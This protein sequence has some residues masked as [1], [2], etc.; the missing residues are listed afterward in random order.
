M[1]MDPKNPATIFA[2]TGEGFFNGDAIQGRGIMR[3]VDGGETFEFMANTEYM[4][5]V[6]RIAIS[7]TD[8]RV[9]LVAS[10]GGTSGGIHLSTDAGATWK[11]VSN[12]FSGKTV[13][14]HPTDG[15][16]AVASV[17]DNDHRSIYS[18]DGGVT[19]SNSNLVGEGFLGRTEL[20]YAPSNPEMVYALCG[21]DGKVYRSTDGGRTY[22][23]RTTS[24]ANPTQLWYDN[25]VWV[26][27]TN[28]ETI[29]LGGVHVRR[30]TDG[31][32]TLNQI[33]SGY[34]MTEQVH[35][36]VHLIVGDP[37]FNG[38]TN[39]KVYVCSDGG[40]YKTEDI[41]AANTVNGWSRLTRDA[42][43]TQFYGAV[44]E[45]ISGKIVGGTQDNGTLM[46]AP[47]TSNAH[48]TYGG[49][50]GWCAINPQDPNYIYG[51][52]VFLQI[53]R[54]TDGGL[55]AEPIYN[56]LVDAFNNQA[57]FIA[58][59]ILDPNNPNVLLAGGRSLWRTTNA[60]G[61]NPFFSPIKPPSNDNISAVAVAKGNSNVI[62]VGHNNGRIFKS[63]NGASPQPTWTEI[64]DNGTTPPPNRYIGRIV[65]AP[66]DPNTLYVGLGG[67]SED[68]LWV[69]RDGGASWSELTGSGTS[70]L[71]RAPIRAIARH[72]FN[73]QTIHVGTEVGI[74]VSFDGGATWSAP[75]DGP[76]NVSVDELNYMENSTKLL[77][78]THGRGLW[79]LGKTSVQKL[80]TPATMAANRT[81]YCAVT[82]DSPAGPEGEVVTLKTDSNAITVPA[83][84]RVSPGHWSVEFA[85]K[86]A[87]VT[88]PVDVRVIANL[89]DLERS[90]T[91]KVGP[92]ELASLS[93]SPTAVVGGTG[94]PKAIVTLDLQ[95][96]AGGLVVNLRSATEGVTIRSSVTVPAGARYVSVPFLT[97]PV[98]SPV[99]ATIEATQ[100]RKTVSGTFTVEPPSLTSVRVSPYAVVGG[101]ATAVTG[102][103]TLSG[104]AP[105]GGITVGLF[106]T[107]PMVA[108]PVGSV[109][110][111]AGKSTATF[112]VEH[113]SVRA[114][115]YANITAVS[116]G[117]LTSVVLHVTP[118]SLASLALDL[119]SVVGGSGTSVTGTLRLDAPAPVGGVSVTMLSSDRSVV[120]PATIQIAQGS[121]TA[122]FAFTAGT[123]TTSRTVTLK[124]TYGATR[125]AQITVQTSA[126]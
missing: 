37:G 109:R 82:L 70:R 113:F 107:S 110:V 79:V 111:E 49:D 66:E 72:P 56:G 75:A 51:E 106:S 24:G 7:P 119:P 53:H 54:S 4:A 62:Y 108:R 3:S 18:V 80:T 1:T 16:K 105:Q 15:T 27:P 58:P 65:V 45:G 60:K 102:T 30:S 28:A 96:P 40:V 39:R 101:S 86:S 55:S 115:T 22:T 59:F 98:A 125:S 33:S 103:V 48:M 67:F 14:F 52:Y 99:T 116:N 122:T 38:T 47:T 94:S 87:A 71:P 74:C 91:I 17:L 95:A 35:P 57:N 114:A 32:V 93:V 26:D 10:Q 21:D 50:G 81:V 73:P 41:Y 121:T 68:N 9:I 118:A 20:A 8:S 120:L 34:I 89:N 123:V 25:H 19:W 29:V 42:R 43:T 78:A 5:N 69:S 12:N 64:G 85:A 44:G 6:N 126:P 84:V 2:G 117:R 83:S 104:R 31:G 100:G 11:V 76:V 77:A 61:F 124:G 112:P 92:A 90:A 13:V 97:T 88:E 36:D 23:E 63:T 46:L